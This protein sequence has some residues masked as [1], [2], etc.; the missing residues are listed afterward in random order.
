MIENTILKTILLSTFAYF[1]A[2]LLSRFMGRKLISQMTFFDFV[3]GVTLGSV[4]AY[5]VLSDQ[6]PLAPITTLITL[7]SL[8]L[9]M[10]LSY[11]RSMKVRKLVNSEP[12]VVIDRG[13]IVNQNMEK[14]RLSVNDLLMLLRQKNCFN[15]GDVE[16]AIMEI[17]GQLSVLLKAQKQ[18]ATVSDLN[19]YT[20]Y[21]GLTRD[22]IMDGHILEE[23]LNTTNLKEYDFL[24]QLKSHGVNDLKEVFYA[25]IDSSGSLYISKRQ[26]TQEYHGKYG[27]D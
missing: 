15:I 13:Q 3:I 21:K 1:L 27:I 8:T 25:G 16:Y 7:T 12:I 2:L 4:T 14:I 23:N 11:I 17:T 10:G 19:I 18:P 26:H 5:I 22:L 6:G 20:H 24:N 9:I